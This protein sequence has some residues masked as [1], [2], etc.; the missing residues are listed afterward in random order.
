MR[1]TEPIFQ[2]DATQIKPENQLGYQI[3]T[4]AKCTDDEK[5]P[6]SP[7]DRNFPIDFSPSLNK[8]AAESVSS[9]RVSG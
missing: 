8:E 4:T 1:K 3:P 9:L 6:S 2:S 5:Q 7:I